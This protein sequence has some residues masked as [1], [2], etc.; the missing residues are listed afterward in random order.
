MSH[1]DNA[2]TMDVLVDDQKPRMVINAD[3]RANGNGPDI[4]WFDEPYYADWLKYGLESWQGTRAIDCRHLTNEELE[5]LATV[6]DAYT[7]AKDL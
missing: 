2:P 5:L 3:I 7:S 4:T 6:V 1:G